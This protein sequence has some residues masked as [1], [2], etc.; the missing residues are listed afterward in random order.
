[1]NPRT[2]ILAVAAAATAV[3][4]AGVAGLF[5]VGAIGTK[6]DDAK[7]DADRKAANRRRGGNAAK[8]AIGGAV[9]GAGAGVI[10]GPIGI[11][12]GAGAGALLGSIAGLLS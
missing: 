6:S 1:M 12:I 4:G 3:V 2:T 5:Y 10:G 9:T 11:A 8:G 7:L